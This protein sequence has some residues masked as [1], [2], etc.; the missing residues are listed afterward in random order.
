MEEADKSTSVKGEAESSAGQW[1][2]CK[3]Y[4]QDPA[5]YEAIPSGDTAR[6]GLSPLPGIAA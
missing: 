3:L 5:Q 1:G 4:T 2:V 6:T